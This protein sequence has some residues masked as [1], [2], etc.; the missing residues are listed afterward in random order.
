MK[1]LKSDYNWGMHAAIEFWTSCL[2]ICYP[3]NMKIKIHEPIIILSLASY[4]YE[5]S[6]TLREGHS[7][8]ILHGESGEFGSI[9]ASLMCGSGIQISSWCQ[10]LTS[11]IFWLLHNKFF[12]TY[13]I[14]W[15]FLWTLWQDLELNISFFTFEA[16]TD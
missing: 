4:E 2:P 13:S 9:S 12:L 14:C 3:I 16:L 5:T 6:L 1:K 15:K 8:C 11:K 10:L 7:S